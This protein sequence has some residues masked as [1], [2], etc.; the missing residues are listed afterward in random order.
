M[1]VTFLKPLL[2]L[3]A[4]PACGL[5]V[6]LVWRSRSGLDRFRLWL[7]AAIRLAAVLALVLALAQAQ[8]VR[9]KDELAV[10]F[11]LDCS[12]S[13]PAET[14]QAALDRIQAACQ[15]MGEKDR[16]ALIPFAADP[17]MET[18]FR[19]RLSLGPVASV[20]ETDRTDL[21]GAMRLAAAAFPAGTQRRVVLVTDGNETSEGALA[22][23]LQLKSLGIGLDV[24]PLSYEHRNEVMAENLLVPPEAHRDEAIE[25]RI[26]VTSMK[27]TDAILSFYQNRQ[28][29]ARQPVHLQ[30]GKNVLTVPRRL[31]GDPDRPTRAGFYTFEAFVEAPG[32][33]L[34][35]NNRT[36]GFTIVQGEA[37]VLLVE[38]AD[39]VDRF[40]HE[41]LA[42]EGFAVD[43]CT[44][45]TLPGGLAELQAYDAVILSNIAA[46]D[47]PRDVLEG[48]P[49]AVRDLGVGL[50]MVGGD[51]SFGAGGYHQTAME[52]VLPVSMD[53]TQRKVVPS[54]ALV[55]ILHTCEFADGNAWA[56]A[57]AAKSLDALS[58]QDWFGELDFGGIGDHW[59]I[60]LQKAKEKTKLRGMIQALTPSDMPSFVNI[61]D[62]AHQGLKPLNASIK[63]CIVI[64]D[65]DPQPPSQAKIQAMVGDRITV[66][67]VGIGPHGGG[68]MAA[69]DAMARW[70]KGRFYNVKDPNELPRIFAKEAET[71]RRALL[72]QETFLPKVRYQT[73]LLKGVEK[74]APPLHGYVATTPK[75]QAQTPIV[76]HLGDPVL[77]HW[78]IGL[79]K[80]V[81]FTSDAKNAW[82]RDWVS[83]A[84]YRGFWA[85]ALRWVMRSTRRGN[86]Q[87]QAEARNG[88]GVVLV[89]A[90]DAEGRLVNDLRMEGRV[91]DPARTGQALNFRQTGPGRYEADFDARQAGA[92]YVSFGY[93]GPGGEQG[94]FTTGTAVSY[95]QE[96]RDLKTNHAL[97]TR[98]AESA[99]GVGE[100]SGRILADLAGVFAHDL[101][102]SRA[103]IEL[104]PA[105]L[106]VAVWAFFADI[107]LRRVLVTRRDLQAAGR[108][109]LALLPSI[110][111][112]FRDHAPTREETLSALLTRKAE[113]Q[114][115]GTARAFEATEAQLKAGEGLAPP[116]DAPRQGKAPPAPALPPTPTLGAREEP[117]GYTERLLEAKRKA[118]EDEKRK[119]QS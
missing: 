50:V 2:L 12:Q 105:L 77:A 23:A 111:E 66:S 15:T 114:R 102:K 93:Q 82:G 16:A 100:G 4:L 49:S 106:H 26:V 60:P 54:G 79:G 32:D 55:L 95:S 59:G 117:K 108:R 29:V 36:F 24:L 70:G 61:F 90:L 6:W 116:S 9:E 37:R 3:L 75:P 21:A 34:L 35:E 84:E 67:T 25:A 113:L 72:C 80:S 22:E 31:S 52:E 1:G 81:A 45:A 91:S 64:S 94:V 74:A 115:E 27:E 47:L 119:R 87:V 19:N 89:D 110:G 103:S 42:Q 30:A 14:R 99:R 86:Y 57:I 88:R 83:W 85:Q 13:V 104:W 11:L 78:R 46:E 33:A 76:S 62:M 97:L 53:L 8:W 39:H 71:V 43:R 69:L 18:A 107:L 38:A 58:P 98:L 63:H 56:K 73:D 7:T 96:F 109:A 48:L 40:L 5:V 41:A 68:E 118:M 112:R 65:G 17:V 101:P 20:L 51:R 10:A 44:P 28:L 92:Y